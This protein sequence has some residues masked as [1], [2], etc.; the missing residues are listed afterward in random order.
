MRFGF[1]I[2]TYNR[3]ENLTLCLE[4]L[5][6]Q[7]NRDFDVVVWDDGSEDDTRKVVADYSNR[8]PIVYGWHPHDGY[9]VSLARNCGARLHNNKVTH[10]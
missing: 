1:V 9:R 4:G 10:F 8:L 3:A 5:L 6:H 2:P 7:T